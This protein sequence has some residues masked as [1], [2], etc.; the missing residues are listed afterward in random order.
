[1]GTLFQSLGNGTRHPLLLGPPFK[2]TDGCKGPPGPEE[3]LHFAGEGA[4]GSGEAGGGF[5]VD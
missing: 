1:M 2:S 4:L 3:G 5:L